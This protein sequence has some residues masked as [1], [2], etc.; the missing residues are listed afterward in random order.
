MPFLL[1]DESTSGLDTLTENSVQEALDRL[2]EKRTV[3]VIAHRLGTIRNADKIIVLKDGRAA[4]EGTH[5][6][7]LARNGLYAEMWNMQ[8]HSKS[9]SASQTN[10]NLM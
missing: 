9:T 4:E 10:L 5:D 8:L 6:E 2:G 3:L 7:L 1:L